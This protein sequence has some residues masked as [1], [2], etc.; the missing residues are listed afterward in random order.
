MSGVDLDHRGPA[1]TSCRMDGTSTSAYSHQY[2]GVQ[3]VHRGT[4]TSTSAY[5]SSAPTSCRMAAS[6][7]PCWYAM[8]HQSCQGASSPSLLFSL[9]FS[10]L[11]E[12]VIGGWDGMGWDTVR[13]QMGDVDVL[14]ELEGRA[15]VGGDGSHASR[16]GDPVTH[17]VYCSV[18]LLCS[19]F[20]FHCIVL[21]SIIHWREKEKGEE[22][23]KKKKKKGWILHSRYSLQ[24]C[25]NSQ[26]AQRQV[27]DGKEKKEKRRELNS[28]DI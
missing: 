23:K 12:G 28:I 19:I 6:T 16:R 9:L 10:F 1:P 14:D 27:S 11:W 20:C 22:E 5:R 17:P 24:D 7:S 21:Y 15:G 3:P 26:D 25:N 2:I 8:S 4:A 18:Y 13:S